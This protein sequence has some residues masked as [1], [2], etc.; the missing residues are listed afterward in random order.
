MTTATNLLNRALITLAAKGGRPR[1]ADPV[2]HQLWTSAS[3]HDRR[4]ATT[5]C[6]GCQ[7]LVLCHEAAEE[8]DERWGVWG[9]RDFTRPPGKRK[10]A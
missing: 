5:W 2:D 9:G 7:V 1:C 4:L 3:E 6:I 8:R 10:A